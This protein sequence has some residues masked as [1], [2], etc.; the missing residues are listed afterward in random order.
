MIDGR[1]GF[2]V[3]IHNQGISKI[4]FLNPEPSIER[5]VLLKEER[6]NRNIRQ[7]FSHHCERYTLTGFKTMV[8]SYN[9][10]LKKE[11]RKKKLINNGVILSG[12]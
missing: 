12:I 6:C 10:R 5:S 11:T 2:A 7:R 3:G 8:K 9:E 1:F 4:E